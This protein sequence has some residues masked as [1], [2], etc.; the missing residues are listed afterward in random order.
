MIA[1]LLVVVTSLCRPKVVI[2]GPVAELVKD[3]QPDHSCSCIQ[4][5]SVQLQLPLNHK[6]CKT[7]PETSW[8]WSYC[9]PVVPP[10]GTPLRG[11]SH[12]FPRII[13][14]LLHFL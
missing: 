12:N 11:T 8:N 6:K 9:G 3:W 5:R 14:I 4:L 10:I 1:L 13:A 7:G 2:A